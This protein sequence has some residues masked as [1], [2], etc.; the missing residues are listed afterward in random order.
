MISASKIEELRLNIAKTHNVLLGK[1]DPIFL[2]VHLNELVLA[3]YLA[4]M[5]ALSGQA[6]DETVAAMAYQVDAAKA[7]ASKLVNETAGFVSADVHNQ[8]RAAVDSSLQEIKQL[9]AISRRARQVLLIGAS[10]F[11]VIVGAAVGI[12]LAVFFKS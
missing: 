4:E 1:D 7:A 5:K 10:I 8:V 11:L 3:D 6:R 2:A 9:A 12:A